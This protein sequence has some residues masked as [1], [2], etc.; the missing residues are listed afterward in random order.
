MSSGMLKYSSSQLFSP[1]CGGVPASPGGGG[2][3]GP[4]L[5]EVRK[6]CS[7]C[8]GLLLEAAGVGLVVAAAVA[9]CWRCC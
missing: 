5:L 9:T 6:S 8:V 4:V 3:R 2:G 7:S 1:H